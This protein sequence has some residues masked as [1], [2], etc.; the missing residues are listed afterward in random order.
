MKAKHGQ[1]VNALWPKAAADKPIDLWPQPTR[2][3]ALN[4]A[5]NQ[6]FHAKI[7]SATQKY[8]PWLDPQ[9]T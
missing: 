1:V 4:Q 3:N 6:L 8:R 5:I 7:I 2:F 9:P